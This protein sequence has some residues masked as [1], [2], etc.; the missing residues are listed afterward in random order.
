MKIL[1]HG[2]V[3]AAL[4]L[5]AATIVLAAGPWR[6]T[7]QGDTEPAAAD[8]GSVP[9]ILAMEISD[10]VEL[11]RHT[12]GEWDYDPGQRYVYAEDADINYPL[13]LSEAEWRGLLEPAAYRILREKGTERAFSHPLNDN[14]QPGVY[15]SRAT[16]QPLFS[17]SDKFDSRTGWP[18]YTRPINPDA[19]IYIE[20]NS[21]FSRRIEVVD[22]LSGSHLGHVFP[23][24]P[25]PTH[26]RYCING[27][28]LVF[29]PDGG[30]PPPIR[31]GP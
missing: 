11:A 17:S 27:E 29:V 19:I 20:D 15:Y 9:A 8:R 22:S 14:A 31:A 10:A 2:P 24:G 28:A 25:A 21:L 30:E 16:G 26:Q 1:S 5:V 18:S 4:I 7:A 12:P 6:V 13:V 3:R 23:D